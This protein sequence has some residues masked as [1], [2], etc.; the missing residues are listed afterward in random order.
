[1]SWP[2]IRTCGRKKMRKVL[3]QAG[4]D[5]SD[6]GSSSICPANGTAGRGRPPEAAARRAGLEDVEKLL[7]SI[8]DGSG[9]ARRFGIRWGMLGQDRVGELIGHRIH[10]DLVIA[11]A[12]GEDCSYSRS[13]LGRRLSARARLLTRIGCCSA[14]RSCAHLRPSTG[15]DRRS[16]LERPATIRPEH[17]GQRPVKLAITGPAPGAFESRPGLAGRKHTSPRWPPGRPPPPAGGTPRIAGQNGCGI[18]RHRRHP[19]HAVAVCAGQMGFWTMTAGRCRHGRGR[20]RR[21]QARHRDG[22]GGARRHGV[23]PGHRWWVTAVT[24]VTAI[25]LPIPA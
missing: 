10:E 22:A 16:T 13:F 4:I 20:H 12:V 8:I 6:Q 15:R 18:E 24:A 17:S 14:H 3:L 9:M 21:R 19:R 11:L 23:C 2:G 7:T 25:P 1:L 5:W